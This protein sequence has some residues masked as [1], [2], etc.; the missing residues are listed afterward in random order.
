MTT[1]TTKA[2]SEW[3]VGTGVNGTGRRVRVH[4]FY[5]I[6]T[7]NNKAVRAFT[8]SQAGEQAEAWAIRLE[9]MLAAGHIR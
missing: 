5:V 9:E 3:G 4:G 1:F 8:G 2:A 7:R 6:D